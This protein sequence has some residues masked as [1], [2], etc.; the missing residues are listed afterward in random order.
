MTNH[1]SFGAPSALTLM[2]DGAIEV[3]FPETVFTGE[4]H[5]FADQFPMLPDDELEALADDIA[6]N[7]QR[8]P[9]MVTAA[10]VLV[11]GRNRLEA[12]RRRGVE[13]WIEVLTGDPHAYIVSA[14]THRRNLNAGQ[15]AMARAMAL[16]QQGQRENGRWKHETVSG[17]TLSRTSL[18]RA[19]FILDHDPAAAALVF[20]GESL[21]GV[22]EA[23]KATAEDRAEQQRQAAELLAQAPDLA[24]QVAE[25]G[26][27]HETAWR[28]HRQRLDR[29][30]VAARE[31]HEADLKRYR[32]TAAAIRSLS[33]ITGDWMAD[34]DTAELEDVARYFTTDVLLAARGQLDNLIDWS[35]Q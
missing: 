6:A 26:I 35:K 17:E 11:D 30:A 20:N 2:A 27:A 10:G 24:R 8:F 15:V 29:E 9:I 14:N 28:M 13:P 12:C 18:F 4:V 7:G 33:S 19:G 25:D 22:Y 5:P 23:V 32:S 3:P 31:R 21:A 34:Y 16:V 1:P